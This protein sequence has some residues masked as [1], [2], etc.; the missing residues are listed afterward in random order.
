MFDHLTTEKRNEKTMNLDEMSTE[1]FLTIM[2]EEDAKVSDLIR[3]N[4][5]YITEAVNHIISSFRS[6]GRLIY[7]GAGTS[8]R[9]GLLDA[10]ECPPTFGTDPRKVVGLIAGGN[11]AFVQAIEGAEDSEALGK[12]DLQSIHLNRTDIVVGIAASG[13][14]PYVTGGLKYAND[15]GADTVAVSNNTGSMIG[16][17]AQI[18]IEVDCGPEVLSGSTRLKAGTAQEM[19]LNMLS[20][21]SMVGIG[22][23]YQNLLVDLQPTN[24]K[25]K[26]RAKII[27]SEAT[28]CD[29]STAETYLE[30]ADHETKVAI[31]M[32][33]NKL[34]YDEAIQRL[35]EAEGVIYKT[36]K[37]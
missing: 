13:R 21:A 35:Q 20:T 11:E 9:L 7:L 36:F 34:S 32:L 2:N 22:K 23:T 8:G 25:L 1:A 3:R 17:I 31:V 24:E 18:K 6:G 28:N 19:I 33:L 29:L 37:P 27:V 4:I 15:I 10:V 16:N 26:Q 14:T 12:H 30:T 5:P